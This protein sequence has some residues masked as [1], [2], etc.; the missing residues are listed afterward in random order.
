MASLRDMIFLL[1]YQKQVL[2]RTAVFV[3]IS[4]KYSQDIYRRAVD[5]KTETTAELGTYSLTLCHW[6]NEVKVGVCA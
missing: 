5:N 3:L 6:N 1:R 4:K 2:V